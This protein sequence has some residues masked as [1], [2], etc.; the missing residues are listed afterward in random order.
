MDFALSNDQ[1]EFKRAVID[2]AKKE[3]EPGIAERDK[4]GVFS[5]ELWTKC[6]EFGV[7][8]MPFP[9]EYGGQGADSLTT[10]LV[11]EGLGEGC[12]DNG[13]IFSINA[14]MWSAVMPIMRF[15][16]DEQKRRYL[17]GLIDGSLIGV[18]GMTEPESGSDAYALATTA[19]KK[20]D[21]F[22][23]N[24]S[25]TF[26]TNA[27]VADLFIVFASVDPS[28]GW[29]GLSAFIVDRDTPGLDVGRPFDK[30]GLRTSPMSDVFF[31]DCEVPAENALAPSGSGMMVFQHSIE[32][33]RSLILANTIG[34]VQRQLD[35]AVSY[36]NQREQFGQSIGKFQA[37][38]HRLVDVR[39]HLEAARLM[40]YQLAWKRDHGGATPLES[41]MVKLFL[42]ENVVEAS[43]ETLQTF[44]G[45]G[46]LSE[47]GLEQ[48]LRDAIASRI[49]SGT[50]DIQR[51]VIA[52]QMGL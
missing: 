3:I 9:A 16:N 44:G 30:M 48:D 31:D 50:S 22:I 32:W 35:N 46:Y 19:E 38:A 17:P 42:S 40:L 27:P 8:G 20:G 26:I 24:G 21:R 51:N 52:H 15:G 34:T 33:E 11:M 6:A 2:F 36:A 49:Y 10:A 43:L 18:Q 7:Q 25:K 5:R 23:L 45:Y 4:D 12:R 37:V 14:H 39:V 41:S 29:A 1:V 13:L 47:S 28:K